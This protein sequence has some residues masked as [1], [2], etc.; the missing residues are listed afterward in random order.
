MSLRLGWNI[1]T[2]LLVCSHLSHL[3]RCTFPV[4]HLRLRSVSLHLS[5]LSQLSCWHICR[6]FKRQLRDLP[7][8]LRNLR[9]WVFLH[10]L[11]L[12]V[13]PLCTAFRKSVHR[14][15]IVSQ[16]F[17]SRLVSELVRVL[18][19]WRTLFI[20]AEGDLLHPLPWYLCVAAIKPHLSPEV[21]SSDVDRLFSS[22]SGPAFSIGSPFFLMFCSGGEE[23]ASD[24]LCLQ[25]SPGQYW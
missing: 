4:P 5:V 23:P 3:P 2:M 17:L 25:H 8:P 22:V 12:W 7:R 19:S 6:L 21:S 14:R 16:Q 15:S 9:K 10:H 13:H 1:R 18:L 11:H 20:A 24:R